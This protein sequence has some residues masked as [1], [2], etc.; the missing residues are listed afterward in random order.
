MVGRGN[1]FSKDHFTG[2]SSKTSFPKG[3]I[4]KGRVNLESE[5]PKHLYPIS[6][7]VVNYLR[8]ITRSYAKNLGGFSNI[9]DLPRRPARRTDLVYTQNSILVENFEELVDLSLQKLINLL[10]NWELN[11][12][13]VHRFCLHFNLLSNPHLNL[14]EESWS[15]CT[16]ESECKSA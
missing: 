8:R 7:E 10:T 13:M 9:L 1:P 6:F 3:S 11:P 16:S 14:L 5:V 12:H 4:P 15:E 2:D